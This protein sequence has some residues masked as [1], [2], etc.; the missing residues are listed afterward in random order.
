M[1]MQNSKRFTHHI[2]VDTCGP[3]GDACG[4]PEPS[5]GGAREDFEMTRELTLVREAG[6]PP[7]GGQKPSQLAG[8]VGSVFRGNELKKRPC[9]VV[10][11]L[12][13]AGVEY[14]AALPRGNSTVAP[15]SPRRGWRRGACPAA[16][17]SLSGYRRHRHGV[18]AGDAMLGDVEE[19]D[20]VLD[21]LQ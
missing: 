12:A 13:G 19:R 1:P 4:C 6:A 7:P 11:P 5:G 21:L 9:R 3:L 2:L 10:S 8:G 14:C 16:T 20:D 15:A 17:R 18:H